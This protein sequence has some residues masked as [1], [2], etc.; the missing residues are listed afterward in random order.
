[1]PFRC[2]PVYRELKFNPGRTATDSA[3]ITANTFQLV[4][5]QPML[6]RDFTHADELAGAA[7]VTILSFR[8]W[9]QRYGRDPAVLGRSVRL[10]GQSTTVIGIMPQGFSRFKIWYQQPR[11]GGLSG[12]NYS[13]RTRAHRSCYSPRSTCDRCDAGAARRPAP[14]RVL[15]AFA[16]ILE[17]FRVAS[18]LRPRRKLGWRAGIPCPGGRTEADVV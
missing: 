9:D 18:P 2:F 15:Q 11:Y 6:G 14:Q 13:S 8:L 10:N 4:G 1:M 3:E 5:R 12:V 7:P 17:A 16:Q